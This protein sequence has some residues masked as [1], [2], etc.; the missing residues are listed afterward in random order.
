MAKC[1]KGDRE[2]GGEGQAD[3]HEWVHKC[4][5][6]LHWLVWVQGTPVHLPEKKDLPEKKLRTS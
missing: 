1:G 5:R 4:T 3:S 2:E 6:S